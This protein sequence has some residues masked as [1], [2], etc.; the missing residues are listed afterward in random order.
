V[1]KDT[2]NG[3]IYFFIIIL[4]VCAV[5]FTGGFITGRSVCQHGAGSDSGRDAEYGRQMGLAAELIGELD[6]GLRNVQTGLSEI[7]RD[8]GTDANN[9]RSLAARLLS[10][11]NRAKEMENDITQLRNRINNFHSYGDNFSD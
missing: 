11:A 1:D 10:A 8:I 5:S 7:A 4:V 9:I 3:I 6:A 2:K